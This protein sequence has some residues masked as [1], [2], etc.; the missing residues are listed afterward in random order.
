MFNSK[1]SQFLIFSIFFVILALLYIYSEETTNPY[2]IDSGKNQLLD[3]LKFETCRIGKLSN[4]S[5]LDF[6]F[7]TWENSTLNYCNSNSITCDI[8][9]IKQVS[10][11]SNLSLLNYSHY[12][13]SIDYKVRGFSYKEGFS[14]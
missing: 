13:Y 11:P 12:N 7:S 14:C 9:I 1:K 6:R 4:G 5:Q 10:A 8:N 2:I 3:N